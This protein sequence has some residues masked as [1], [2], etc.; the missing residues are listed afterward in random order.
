MFSRM[1]GESAVIFR[2]DCSAGWDRKTGRRIR[3]NRIRLDSCV[4]VKSAKEEIVQGEGGERGTGSV[5]IQSPQDFPIYTTNERDNASADIIY[6][7]GRYW[8]VMEVSNECYYWEAKIDMLP[9]NECKLLGIE[10]D[11]CD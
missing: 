2:E 10:E 1:G 7:R 6:L 11:I 4:V 9:E 5:V 3:S 8:K